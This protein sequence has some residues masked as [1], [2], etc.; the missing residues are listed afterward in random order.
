[1]RDMAAELA[2]GTRIRRARERRR[3]TQQQLAD[4]L[5]VSVRT[6]NDWENGRTQPRNSVGAIEHVLGIRLDGRQEAEPISDALR[7]QIHR[8]LGPE[9]ARRV[10]GVLEGTLIV[11]PADGQEER[12]AQRRDPA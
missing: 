8:E 4:A 1:M 5:T 2:L 10:I 9:A 11:R 7:A 12:Q 3:W 6:V